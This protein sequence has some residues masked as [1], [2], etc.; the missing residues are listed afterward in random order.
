[1]LTHLISP[2]RRRHPCTK[3]SRSAPPPSVRAVVEPSQ[4]REGCAL[5]DTPS[6]GVLQPGVPAPPPGLPS[7]QVHDVLRLRRS[8]PEARRVPDQCC[9]T[10]NLFGAALGTSPR[11]RVDEE[12]HDMMRTRVQR[13]SSWRTSLGR[14]AAAALALGGL[15]ALTFAPSIATAATRP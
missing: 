2:S 5:L 15:S 10:C 9:S 6:L 4:P 7:R 13:A 1:E 11:A 14:I 12:V 8:G 3:R